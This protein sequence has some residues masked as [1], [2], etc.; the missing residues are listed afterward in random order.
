MHIIGNL[1]LFEGD[2]TGSIVVQNIST[3]AIVSSMTT[4]NQ[5]WFEF[6]GLPEETNLKFYGISGKEITQEE[7]SQSISN[8]H[9]NGYVAI[10]NP[11]QKEVFS[12]HLNAASTYVVVHLESDTNMTYEKANEVVKNDANFRLRSPD[13]KFCRYKI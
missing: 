11:N 8:E 1:Q 10:L 9:F 3:K 5:G 12:V 2:T 4:D 7:A 13:V 6:T